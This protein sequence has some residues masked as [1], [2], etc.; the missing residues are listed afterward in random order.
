M[1]KRGPKKPIQIETSE[2]CS[3]G[4]G[5]VARFQNKSGKL[6]C[7]TSANKC[8]TNREKNSKAIEIAH[9]E[10]RCIKAANLTTEHRS[11][12]KGKRFAEFGIPGK[13]QFKNALI[14]ERGHQCEC[15][16]NTEWLEKPITLELEHIDGNR[17]NNTRKNLKLLCPNCHSQTVTWR[18]RNKNR[19]QTKISD[20]DFL[21][22]I[23]KNRNIK[24]ALSQL[25]L[26]PK[27]AN[28]RRAYELSASGGMAYTEDLKPSASA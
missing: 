27:A 16:K 12:A 15:C 20:E 5:K 24:D 9:K 28:Y 21:E 25:G 22:A 18:G 23:K 4:C 7:N 3:Y 6:M 19:I 2:L 26:T 13:G 10:G 8:L 17:Q 1:S 14:S 11:N